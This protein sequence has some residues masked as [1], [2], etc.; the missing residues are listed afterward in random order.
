MSTTPEN[1]HVFGLIRW[2]FEPL[3]GIHPGQNRGIE[4]LEEKSF[5]DVFEKSRFLRNDDCLAVALAWFFKKSIP[6]PVSWA[7]RLARQDP[8]S[9]ASIATDRL[10]EESKTLFESRYREQLGTG[11]VL[12]APTR[13]RLFGYVPASPSL[14]A[15]CGKPGSNLRIRIPNVLG[16]PSQFLPPSPSSGRAAGPGS[17]GCWSRV[18]DARNWTCQAGRRIRLF[19]TS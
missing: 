5:K 6:L 14:L 19:P 4:R 18:L 3:P 1:L 17:S 11:L 9:P 2:L 12:K 13:D 10:P 7:M 8:R 16:I 15:E